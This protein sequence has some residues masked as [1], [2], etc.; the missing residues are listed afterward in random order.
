[1]A[2]PITVAVDAM[3]GDR[4]PAAVVAGAVAAARGRDL[5]VVLVGP[6]TAIREELA[7]HRADDLP[8]TLLDA[9]DVVAMAEAPLAALRRKRRA[10]IRVA[11]DLVAQG[12]AQA[13]FT[14][15]HTGAAVLT[16]HATFG[17]LPGVERPALAVI[18]PAPRGAA[19]LLDA[20]ANV[21]C[22]PDHLERFGVMGAAYATVALNI[23]RPRVGLLSI[24]EEAGK[25]NDLVREAHGLLAAA[26]VDFI[27]N[28]EA[29][30]MFAG[31]ADVIVCDGFTGN[32]AL[33]VGEGLVEAVEQML[34]EELGAEVVSQVGALLTRRAFARFKQ[35]VD[36]AEYGGAP[37]LGVAGLVVVGHG[38]STPHA[39]ETGIA[40]AA[41]LAAGGMI[42]RLGR[43]LERGSG[44]QAA[45]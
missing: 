28:L 41:R 6:E 19:I 13:V 5:R 32:I 39:V 7:Q 43:A 44:R 27:G 34:R 17:V 8:I 21:D 29:R 22:R 40:L 35:R 30:D 1:M 25:G 23:D 11:A 37:L 16:A 36:A 14:A 18:V 4:A 26:P 20:G 10:S 24:G 31:Q 2:T 9:P 15:G 45:G 38:R 33:K 3:G 12:G 42:G